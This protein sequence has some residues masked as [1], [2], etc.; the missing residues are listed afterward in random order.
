MHYFKLILLHMGSF[1]LKWNPLRLILPFY[2]L[3]VLLLCSNHGALA[4]QCSYLRIPSIHMQHVGLS[5]ESSQVSPNETSVC[6]PRCVSTTS[7]QSL[8]CEK[9]QFEAKLQERG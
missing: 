9:H 7:L 3:Y 1:I 8:R 2:F 4:Q 5:E 6:I